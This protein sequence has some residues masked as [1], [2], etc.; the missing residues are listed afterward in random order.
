MKAPIYLIDVSKCADTANSLIMAAN[1]D[2]DLPSFFLNTDYI[3]QTLTIK[4]TP[5]HYNALKAACTDFDLTGQV[6]WPAATCLSEYLADNEELIRGKDCLELGSG[7]GIVGLYASGIARR[8]VLTDGQDVVMDLLR[9][10]AQYARGP[11][12]CHKLDWTDPLSVSSL[13]SSGLPTQYPVLLGADIVH[14][15]TLLPPMI[16]TVTELL[17]PEGYFLLG[18]T[19]RAELTT[20]QLHETLQTHNLRA[21]TVYSAGSNLVLRIT[22]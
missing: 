2:Y 11:V 6:P 8:V 16:R 3:L 7:T 13:A 15:P 17:S 14:W 12:T 19:V 1:D 21:E 20:G 9:S 18:Y 10:N 4:G 22:F 5:L